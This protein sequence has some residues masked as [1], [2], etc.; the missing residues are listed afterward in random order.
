MFFLK[1]MTGFSAFMMPQCRIAYGYYVAVA[2]LICQL[3]SNRAKDI[4]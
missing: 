4:P 2:S 1:A 3:W